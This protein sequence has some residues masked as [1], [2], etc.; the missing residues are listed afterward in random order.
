MTGN[1]SVV[2]RATDG[3]GEVQTADRAAPHPAGSTGYHFLDVSVT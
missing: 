2:C 1:V 3:D